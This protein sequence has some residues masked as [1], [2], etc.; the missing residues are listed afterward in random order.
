MQ[1]W[2]NETKPMKMIWTKSMQLPPSVFLLELN[3]FF[4]GDLRS[5]FPDR[6]LME[7]IECLDGEGEPKITSE[8]VSASGFPK[9]LRKP[10]SRKNYSIRIIPCVMANAKPLFSNWKWFVIFAL[11]FWTLFRS[12]TLVNFPDFSQV[13]NYAKSTFPER[14]AVC[15]VANFRTSLAR[16][17]LGF[18]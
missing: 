6:L 13:R 4:V 11:S 17:E 12:S 14:P 8:S 1:A 5:N 2:G 3:S 10:W 7:F 16:L 18:P 15:S 9:A